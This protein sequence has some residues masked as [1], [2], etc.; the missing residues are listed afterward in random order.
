MSF[1]VEATGTITIDEY[2]RLKNSYDLNEYIQLN[3]SMYKKKRNWDEIRMS[4]LKN[5]YIKKYGNK[6]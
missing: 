3:E 6:K 2:E 1:Q 4:I 5:E